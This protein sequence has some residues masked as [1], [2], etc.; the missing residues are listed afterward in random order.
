MSGYLAGS[1]RRWQCDGM[2]RKSEPSMPFSTPSLRGAQRRSNP[3]ARTTL[4]CFATLAMT[5]EEFSQRLLLV[6]TILAGIF[7]AG[8]APRSLQ[9]VRRA[10]FAAHRLDAG[11]ALL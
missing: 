10:A 9:P 4:D 6:P 7:D 2:S 3:A 11:I 5:P 8:F 1:A